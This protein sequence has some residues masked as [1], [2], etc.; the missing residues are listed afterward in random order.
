VVEALSP[1]EEMDMFQPKRGTVL[2]VGI[3]VFSWA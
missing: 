2:A 1:E 3:C